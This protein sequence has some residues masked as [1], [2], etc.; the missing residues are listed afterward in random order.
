VSGRLRQSSISHNLKG[1]RC[2]VGQPGHGSTYLMPRYDQACSAEVSDVAVQ[3]SDKHPR[4]VEVG[5][6]PVIVDHRGSCRLKF[7]VQ[8]VLT[9]TMKVPLYCGQDSVSRFYS[10]KDD[11]NT[12]WLFLNAQSPPYIMVDIFASRARP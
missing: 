12:L 9:P 10:D 5:Q 6:W 11:P 7:Y 8:C 2:G 4:T 1:G 3:C